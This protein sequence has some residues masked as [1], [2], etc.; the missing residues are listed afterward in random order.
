MLRIGYS[1]RSQ[2]PPILTRLRYRAFR[3]LLVVR[4]RLLIAKAD[5]PTM[6]SVTRTMHWFENENS[7]YIYT[8]SSTRRSICFLLFRKRVADI[9]ASNSKIRTDT[10]SNHVN[11]AKRC[12]YGS[13]LLLRKRLTDITITCSFA[14]YEKL[15]FLIRMFKSCQLVQKENSTLRFCSFMLWRI[16]YF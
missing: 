13:R 11:T 14:L 4:K 15:V 1:L 6:R 7:G 16:L 12:S 3:L 5:A 9:Y 8:G 2:Q 10:C